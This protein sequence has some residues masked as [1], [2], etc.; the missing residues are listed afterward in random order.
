MCI[1]LNDI[2]FKMKINVS[3][4]GTVYGLTANENDEFTHWVDTVIATS[5]PEDVTG[6][7]FVD[8]F[9]RDDKL[10]QLSANGLVSA[11]KRRISYDDFDLTDVVIEEGAIRE[12]NAAKGIFFDVS[13]PKAGKYYTT[14]EAQLINQGFID[15]R[16]SGNMVI[17]ATP[18]HKKDAAYAFTV[19]RGLRSVI[20]SRTGSD[21]ISYVM[22]SGKNVVEAK[23]AVDPEDIVRGQILPRPFRPNE[24]N[25]NSLQVHAHLISRT[26]GINPPDFLLM[27]T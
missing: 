10:H 8:N 6:T 5:E 16:Y 22:P 21:M 23:I 4:E 15:P 12:T 17:A 18:P 1:Q 14:Y 24:L 25:V 7:I 9:V 27:D 19:N 11:I 2:V 20:P 26:L 13:D 3:P